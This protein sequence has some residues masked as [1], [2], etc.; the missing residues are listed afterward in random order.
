M[1]NLQNQIV[2]LRLPAQSIHA[3][4]LLPPVLALKPANATDLAVLTNEAVI[5]LL[6]H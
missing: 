1:F 5:L 3:A 6:D 4:K 2:G